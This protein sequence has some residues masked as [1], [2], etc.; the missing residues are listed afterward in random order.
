MQIYWKRERTEVS[1]V[2]A[3]VGAEVVEY[4]YNFLRRLY[5]FG[6]TNCHSNYWIFSENKRGS[7]LVYK[8]NFYVWNF[9]FWL[10]VYFIF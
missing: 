6:R 8:F 1:C 3:R 10:F 5:F 9:L 7:L 4:K 2:E